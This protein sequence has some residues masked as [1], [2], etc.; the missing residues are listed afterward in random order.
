[1][2]NRSFPHCETHR[3]PA[4]RPDRPGFTLPELLLVISIIAV[5]IGLLLPVLASTR[6]AAQR[7]T[8]S[9]NLRQIGVAFESYTQASD[10]VFPDARSIPSPFPS[11]L[12][13]PPLMTYLRYQLAAGAPNGL[14]EVYLCP[15]DATV[16]PLTNMSY[17]YSNFVNGVE[18]GEVLNRGFIQMMGFTESS[19]LVAGDFDGAPGGSD[20]V[21]EDGTTIRVPKRHFK[22]N[23]LFADGHVDIVVPD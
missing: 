3:S 11:T 6:K 21:L 14:S 20:F 7:V 9:A 15:D 16:S 19:L 13:T 23:L 1:M 2:P 17:G 4:N 10:G 5:L 22:R 12:T 18:L 8:C